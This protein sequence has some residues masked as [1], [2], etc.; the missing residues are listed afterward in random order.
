MTLRFIDPADCGC[1]DCLTGEA[2]PLG[3]ATAQHVKQ[4]LEGRLRWRAGSDAELTINVKIVIPV[5]ELHA[6]TSTYLR[7]VT[8]EAYS[9][10]VEVYGYSFNI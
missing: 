7:V 4:L 5:E 10:D 2:V 3:R 8:R 9:A 1:T 6:D